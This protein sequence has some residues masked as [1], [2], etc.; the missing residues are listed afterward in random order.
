MPERFVFKFD[1]NQVNVGRY[2]QHYND[3]VV[4]ILK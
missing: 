3:T 2:T 4:I 1:G